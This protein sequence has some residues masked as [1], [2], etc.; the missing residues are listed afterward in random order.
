MKKP[1]GFLN[2]H[3]SCYVN[4]VLQALLTMD[5]LT[6]FMKCVDY[7]DPVLKTFT[8]IIH[9]V[10][11]KATEKKTC[12]VKPESFLN[13]LYSNSYFT[14]GT[15]EDAHELLLFLIDY[16]HEKTKTSKKH[17]II[18]SLFNGKLTTR[19]LCECGKVSENKENFIH[20]SVEAECKTIRNGVNQYLENMEKIHSLCSKCELSTDKVLSHKISILPEY[21][22][23]QVMRFNNNL[24]KKHNHVSP[25]TSIRIM[26][27][28]YTLSGVIFHIGNLSSGHYY[29]GKPTKDSFMMIDD[30][31]ITQEQVINKQNVYLAI[32]KRD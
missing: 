31:D 26:D 30:N 14:K 9:Y 32:Y 25:D 6:D 19:M 29:F 4:S 7:K 28:N 20:I 21:L 27:D 15:Q 8:G 23:V 2:V 24:S 17:S 13:A 10:D 16:I 18:K 11:E 1:I 22:I 5:K 12:V 3:N